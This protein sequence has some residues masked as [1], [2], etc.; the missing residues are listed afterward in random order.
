MGATSQLV[1]AWIDPEDCRPFEIVIIFEGGRLLLRLVE[2][3][4][5][6]DYVGV[7]AGALEPSMWISDLNLAVSELQTSNF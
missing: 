3:K 7:T 4:L 6:K 5:C 2:G 1:W